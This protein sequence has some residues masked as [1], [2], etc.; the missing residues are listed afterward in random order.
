MFLRYVPLGGCPARRGVE[1]LGEDGGGTA[2]GGV[3]KLEDLQVLNSL[4]FPRVAG[5]DRQRM[6]Q[7]CHTFTRAAGGPLPPRTGTAWPTWSTPRDQGG[8]KRPRQTQSLARLRW[9][10]FP[11][12]AGHGCGF[13]LSDAACNQKYRLAQG[14]WADPLYKVFGSR[15]SGIQ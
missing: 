15:N 12:L 8:P 1:G 13:I 2:C 5:D 10:F 3:L 14:N 9:L 4:E 6:D 7:H 11:S